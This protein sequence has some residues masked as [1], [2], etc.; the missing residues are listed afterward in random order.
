MRP[1]RG[2]R[3]FRSARHVRGRRRPESPGRFQS[4]WASAKIGLPTHG[5]ASVRETR[6]LPR[7]T[8]SGRR[9]L[10]GCVPPT[11]LWVGPDRT[12]VVTKTTTGAA[13]AGGR[14]RCDGSTPSELWRRWWCGPTQGAVR[15]LSLGE[16]KGRRRTEI[17]GW[18]DPDSLF[19][20]LGPLRPQGPDETSVSNSASGTNRLLG[21]GLGRNSF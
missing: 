9:G 18:F 19:P 4:P 14:G 10:D 15:L 3:A 5:R 11:C 20:G 6:S 1:S 21:S 17:E 16:G 2:A 8:V 13:L 12:P 7:S